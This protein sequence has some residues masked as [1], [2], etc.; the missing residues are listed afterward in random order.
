MN[1]PTTGNPKP[2]NNRRFAQLIKVKPEKLDYYKALHAKPWP[3]VLKKLKECNFQN[4]SIFLAPGNL[5][6]AYFEYVGHDF[7]ADQQK[8]NADS[9]TQLWWKETDP[10]QE[11]ISG[12]EGSWWLELE[13]VF[14]ME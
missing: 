7:E 9:C 12:E 5:L 2:G 8:I 3:C 4:Y 13:E 1:S 6:F 14:Y 11:S 10:C